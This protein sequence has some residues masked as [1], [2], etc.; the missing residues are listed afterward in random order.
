L[1]TGREQTF[2]MLAQPAGRAKKQITLQTQTLQFM[3]MFNEGLQ[4]LVGAIERRVILR[5]IEAEFDRGD[6]ACTER[7]RGAADDNSNQKP[8][9]KSP[10]HNDQCDREQ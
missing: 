8:G 9:D 4:L 10:Y 6:P 5:F 3:S 2:D 7:E 1:G